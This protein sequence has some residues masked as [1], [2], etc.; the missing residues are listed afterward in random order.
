MPERLPTHYRYGNRSVGS[1]IYQE[2][3]LYCEVFTTLSE[4]PKGYWIDC[5]GKKK[6]VSKTST[7]RYAYPTL[8]EAM[9]AFKKRKESQIRILTNQ[10]ERAKS[11]LAMAND[12]NTRIARPCSLLEE[13]R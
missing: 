12:G 1:D 2:E 7:K 6:W 5:Y 11:A 10:L 8:K 3:I 13:L 4:T 9:F